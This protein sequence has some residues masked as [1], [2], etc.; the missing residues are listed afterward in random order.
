MS[1]V[2][3]G[4]TGHLGRLVVEAVLRRGLPVEELVATG[5]S[6]DKLKDLADRGVT[7]RRADFDDRESVAA[8]LAGAEK[9]LLVSSSEVGKRF[10]QHRNVIDAARAAG[11]SRL[12]YTSIANA[13]RAEMHLAREHQETEQYLRTSGVPAAVLRNSWY[14]ENYT[15]QLA[16]TLHGGA[17]L[18]CAGA[19][20]V[21]A[22]TRADY[23]EAAA[24][25]LLG[26]DNIEPV[27]ELGGDEAF[28]LEELAA[29]ISRVT[30]TRVVYR[31]LPAPVYARML[32]DAGL[33]EDYAGALADAD[34]GLS[35][36]E[37]L[38]DGDELS[39]LIG[40]PTTTLADAIAAAH[41]R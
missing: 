8:V 11:V 39:R 2:V 29:E 41:R 34:V 24:A 20:R 14:V 4:A 27:Y 40:R 5:R 25:V 10:A 35:R 23:A 18:G 26:E 6:T 15:D 17:V 36:G 19:G 1:I 32:I 16:A 7:V 3:T 30:G 21:S 9:V 13:D 37:L 31:D 33:P 38:V 28:S 12:V 22:T